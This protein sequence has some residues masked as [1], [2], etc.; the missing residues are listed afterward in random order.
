MKNRKSAS[1]SEK[2]KKSKSK[3][4]LVKFLLPPNKVHCKKT[5]A[6]SDGAGGSEETHD[7]VEL[8]SVVQDPAA[9]KSGE[10][11]SSYVESSHM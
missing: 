3:S 10:E 2:H 1:K 6:V 11:N 7:E 5:K 8:I 4:M 9:A